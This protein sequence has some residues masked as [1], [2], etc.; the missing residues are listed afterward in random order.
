MLPLLTCNSS[1]TFT[2]SATFE[3]S[4]ERG[5]STSWQS[6]LS[7]ATF[8]LGLATVVS[9]SPASSQAAFQETT[10][11]TK[12]D[13]QQESNGHT[14]RP[15]NHLADETSPYLLMHARNPVDWYPWGEEA[16]AKAKE[17]NKPI[18]LSV[19]YSSCHWCHVMERESFLD[20]EIA[21]F[22]NEHFVCIKVDREER[23]DIDSIY[24]RGL[25]VY[26]TLSRQP[27]HGGWPLSVFITPE[28]E[29]F[30]GG[31]YFPA[32]DGDREGHLGFFTLLKRIETGWRENE[33]SIRRDAKT[34]ARVTRQEL[35]GLA[36]SD[37]FELTP[38]LVTRTH[39]A[40]LDT[41]DEEYG[42]FSTSMRDNA[43]KF[44]EPSNLMFLLAEWASPT[45]DDN[46]TERQRQ[47]EQM[48]RTTLDH[49]VEGGIRDHLAGGFHRYTVDRDW[50]I[51]HFEKMLYD[52][53]QLASL[54][55]RA[56]QQTEDVR[57]QQA[58]RELVKF[59]AKEMTSPEGGFYAALDAES[60]GVEGKYYR[61]T[62]E[63]IETALT[64]AKLPDE[65]ID[66]FQRAYGINAEPNFED[67]YALR[68]PQSIGKLA[69]EL[70]VS[71]P[72]LETELTACR[73]ALL[74]VRNKRERPLTDSKILC[75]WN[76]LMITGLVDASLAL[77][78]EQALQMAK[79]A[80]NFVVEKMRQE[81]GGLFRT[82][83]AGEA[84]LN[85]YADDY[86]YLVEGL[87]A[88][89]QATG[90]AQ[91]LELALEISEEQLQRFWDEDQGGFF[92]TSTGHDSLLARAKN[93]V[94][95][96]TPSAT[97]VSTANL[98]RLAKLT[99]EERWRT[100]ADEAI[101]STSGYLTKSPSYSPRL[102]VSVM[103]LL[104][105]G[106]R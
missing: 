25:F 15:L 22:L 18:F 8:L 65:S 17:E 49:I 38:S 40:L 54:L 21:A 72:E 41:F 35:E 6:R 74:K 96:A 89:H 68:L 98:L 27:V 73:E 90:D 95:Q 75:G 70:G 24:M 104:R 60:D 52:Q 71:Q 58:L 53:A 105:E 97:S 56:C 61:W 42:G 79:R 3:L 33:E 102:M 80:A 45:A 106:E 76:G 100:R 39:D 63:E 101:R 34:I 82:Y 59:V 93:P 86:A 12:N 62:R 87:L 48:L 99:E 46:E 92:F 29:P 88:L 94:D 13:A 4:Y 77:E 47:A 10:G 19:G 1:R 83:A 43:P 67:H 28:G 23:P 81:D 55:A 2:T 103:Q 78:D 9:V 85:A 91:W 44:P 11:E 64:D 31:T 36:P 7:A 66:H 14:D 57:Y 37:D 20:E 32:R 16:L 84:K 5:R 69:D 51:P 50:E 26:Q 30:F